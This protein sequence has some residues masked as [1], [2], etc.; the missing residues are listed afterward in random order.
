MSVEEFVE[1]NLQRTPG[2][3]TETDKYEFL[4]LIHQGLDR[5][6]A[7]RRLGFVGRHFRA[8][9]SPQSIFY[10]EDFARDYG[11]AI[12]SVEFE[13]NRLERLRAEAMRRALVDSDRLLEKLLMVH[14]PDWSVLRERKTESNVNIAVLVQQQLKELPTDKLEQI[15]SLIE[16]G[17]TVDAEIIEL[18]VGRSDG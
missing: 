18:P 5:S 4:Q 11:Q 7:A 16:S 17:E 10:D 8:I 1:Q 2:D 13:T 15:L 12:S 9:C 6:E 3:I 14:D